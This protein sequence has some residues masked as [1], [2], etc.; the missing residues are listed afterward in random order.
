MSYCDLDIIRQGRHVVNMLKKP[1]LSDWEPLTVGRDVQRSDKFCR[2]EREGE[3][4]GGEGGGHWWEH[5][6]GALTGTEG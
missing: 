3:G 1:L 2:G 4:G 6:N 5:F